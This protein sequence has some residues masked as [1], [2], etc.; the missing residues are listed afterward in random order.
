MHYTHLLFIQFTMAVYFYYP[1]SQL[2]LHVFSL[3]LRDQIVIPI[4]PN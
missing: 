3:L 2:S 4:G 1:K